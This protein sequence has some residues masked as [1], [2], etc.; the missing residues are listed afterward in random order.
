MVF[1]LFFIAALFTVLAAI[2]LSTYAD[3]LS[4][5]TSLGGMMIGTIFLAGATSLPEVTTSLTAIG[6][7]NPDLAVGNVLGSN[8]FNLLIIASFDLYFRKKQIFKGASQSNLYTVYLGMFLTFVI[9]LAL[10]L[11]LPYSVFGIGLDAILLLVIY[12]IGMYALSKK[13][14]E[15]EEDE[16]EVPQISSAISLKRAIIGFS[17]AAIVILLAGS[18]LAITGDKIAVITGLG[19]SFV[20]SFL[21]AATTSLPE[22]VAVLIAIQL[23]NYN[24]AIG[25]VLGSNVFNILILIG[26]DVFYRPAPI[27]STVSSVHSITAVATFILSVIVVYSLVRFK[28]PRFQTAYWIPS[29][30]LIIVYFVSSLLIFTH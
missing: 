17:I 14:K 7:N 29:A 30:V 21:I 22:A 9:F 26:A 25:S 2:K 18:L 6:L 12:V 10:T 27:I 28:L 20:G 1:L 15:G 19:S 16:E 13:A 11:K 8:L 3:V 24:L 5:K 23:R 4:E